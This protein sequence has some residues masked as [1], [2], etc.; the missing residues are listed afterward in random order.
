MPNVTVGWSEELEVTIKEWRH[1]IYL[2][3]YS[4]PKDL[5]GNIPATVDDLQ[6]RLTKILKVI[7]IAI[8]LISEGQSL[9]ELSDI[10]GYCR[11]LRI[12]KYVYHIHL[13]G[14]HHQN[15]VLLFGKDR[16]HIEFDLKLYNVATHDELDMK[17]DSEYIET[18]RFK[19]YDTEYYKYSEVQWEI[20]RQCFEDIQ[21]D[22]D[23]Y[24]QDS[25]V[26]SACVDAHI[27]ACVSDVADYDTLHKMLEY[28]QDKHHVNLFGGIH[29]NICPQLTDDE[30][31]YILGLFDF[32]GIFI[33]D[34]YIEDVTRHGQ[35]YSYLKVLCEKPDDEYLRARME[36]N[37]Y[38]LDDMLRIRYKIDFEDATTIQYSYN[39]YFIYI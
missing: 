22:A 9:E 34:Y 11:I 10:L 35:Q 29:R 37:M 16:Y 20:A 26:R 15:L 38:K 14:V 5:I 36:S 6:Q 12:N 39:H 17:A 8:Q 31:D 2:G 3:K 19:E 13:D 21:Q 28:L 33:I 32:Y 25:A 7:D 18:Q 24:S 1:A 4:N 30:V 23:L 27:N